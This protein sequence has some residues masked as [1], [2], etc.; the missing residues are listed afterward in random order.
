[1]EQALRVKI[2]DSSPTN[3]PAEAFH[4]E[5]VILSGHNEIHMCLTP[6]PD[7]SQLDESAESWE[8][9]QRGAEFRLE[10]ARAKYAKYIGTDKLRKE[11]T[12]GWQ[13]EARERG[14]R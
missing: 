3:T 12:D 4:L 8:A 5:L 11:S 13:K 6:F 10:T 9:C 14:A 1:M 7:G 2:K